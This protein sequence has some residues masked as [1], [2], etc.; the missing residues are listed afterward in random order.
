MSASR[1]RLAVTLSAQNPAL[2]AA[3]VWCWGQ[4]CQKQPSRNTATLARENTRS[5]VR[6]TLERGRVLTRYRRPRACTADRRAS[7][8]RVS[9]PRLERMLARTPG[10]DAH[11]SR[12]CAC[13]GARGG[14]M[15]TECRNHAPIGSCRWACLA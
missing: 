12:S 1:R 11:D 7:S 8:G 9:R 10:E 2:V 14:G 15:D 13:F 6:R 5:A 3:T 4:P